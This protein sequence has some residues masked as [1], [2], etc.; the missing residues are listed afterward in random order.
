MEVRLVSGS[1]NKVWR[2]ERPRRRGDDQTV[3]V[4]GSIKPRKLWNLRGR[5]MLIGKTFGLTGA[6]DWFWTHKAVARVLSGS[7]RRDLPLHF[8]QVKNSPR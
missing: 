7:G 1:W 6:R 4:V 3:N 2:P 5:N 8:D